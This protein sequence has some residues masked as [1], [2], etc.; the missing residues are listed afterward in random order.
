MELLLRLCVVQCRTAVKTF[1]RTH[2]QAIII[3]Y[4]LLIVYGITKVQQ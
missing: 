4:D 2:A 3:N 1:V